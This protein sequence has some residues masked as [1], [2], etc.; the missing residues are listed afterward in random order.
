MD[1]VRGRCRA[2]RRGAGPG[3]PRVPAA[4]GSLL[5]LLLAGVYLPGLSDT[6][7]PSRS[8]GASGAPPPRPRLYRRPS[9]WRCAPRVV[10][11][12]RRGAPVTKATLTRA[13]GNRL[14]RDSPASAPE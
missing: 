3:S 6:S 14:E 12:A 11:L 13:G 7:A 2:W 1:L 5:L 9:C 10:T 8:D 4:A